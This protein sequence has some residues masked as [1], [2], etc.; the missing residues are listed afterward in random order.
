MLGTIPRNPSWCNF[1][2]ETCACLQ[3]VAGPRLYLLFSLCYLPSLAYLLR[4]TCLILLFCFFNNLCCQL[5]YCLI[6]DDIFIQPQDPLNLF[7]SSWGGRNI[8]KNIITDRIFFNLKGHFP[9]S[10]LI[11]P[12]YAAVETLNSLFYLLDD[13]LYGIIRHI[14]PHNEDHLVIVIHLYASLWIPI[15]QSAH[16]GGQVSPLD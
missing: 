15:Q 13:T 6:T 16:R 1:S 4:L 9:F 5:F 10:P 3:T 8:H 14:R 7:G 12:V 11:N 2:S